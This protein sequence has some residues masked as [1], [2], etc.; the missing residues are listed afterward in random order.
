MRIKTNNVATIT[1]CISHALLF[2]CGGSGDG[3]EA[4]PP[5]QSVVPV[6]GVFSGTLSGSTS[7]DFQALVLSNGGL[8]RYLAL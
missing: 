4:S 7:S 3:V 1:L 8:W 5:P 6:E 2:G